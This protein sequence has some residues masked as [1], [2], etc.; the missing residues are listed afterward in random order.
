VVAGFTR[1]TTAVVGIGAVHPRP[2]SVV[3]S[4]VPERFTA[5]LMHSGAIGEVQGYLFAEDGH[6]VEHRLWRHTLNITPDQLRRVGRVVAAAADPVKAR[7]VRAVCAAGVPTDL[8]VDVEL[9]HALLQLPP[10]SA[11]A[12]RAASRAAGRTGSRP[13][14]R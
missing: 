14:A 12:A 6:T 10:T 1:L 9:A 7:A 3:C 2:I 11:A 8:V 4:Q 13:T 5:Q